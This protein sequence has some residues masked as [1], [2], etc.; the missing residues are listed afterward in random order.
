MPDSNLVVEIMAALNAKWPSVPLT[1]VNGGM[2]CIADVIRKHSKVQFIDRDATAYDI[3]PITALRAAPATWD[4]SGLIPVGAT[5]VIIHMSGQLTTTSEVYDS[6]V[7]AY[8]YDRGVIS[9]AY[10]TIGRGAWL[11]TP[12]KSASAGSHYAISSGT[13]ILP[14]GSSRKLYVF[15]GDANTVGYNMA[16]GWTY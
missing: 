9:N 6:S 8:D 2:A 11:Y 10:T 13:F 14:I 4:L 1:D 3:G 5:N 15:R 12:Y 7:G 16:L